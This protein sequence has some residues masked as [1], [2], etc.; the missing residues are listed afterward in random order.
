MV[1]P[2]WTA[3][4]LVACVDG[5]MAGQWYFET[6]WNDRL[7]AARYMAGKGQRRAVCLDYVDSG[8]RVQH[9]DQPADGRA[10]RYQ[11]KEAA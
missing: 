4:A 3:L 2:D 1:T 7:D 5:P 10:L 8:N 6:E 9:P 11:P